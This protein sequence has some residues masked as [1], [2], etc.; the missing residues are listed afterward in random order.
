MSS[1]PS[2]VVHMYYISGIGNSGSVT[3]SVVGSASGPIAGSDPGSVTGSFVESS[4]V[5]SSS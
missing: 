5:A 1:S 3:V 2:S 4:E